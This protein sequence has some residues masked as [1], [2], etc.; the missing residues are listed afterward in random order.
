MQLRCPPDSK[1]SSR[2]EPLGSFLPMG[3]P[4]PPFLIPTW[5]Y[6]R[7]CTVTCVKGKILLPDAEQ[8]SA[9][10]CSGSAAERLKAAQA[11]AVPA[12]SQLRLRCLGV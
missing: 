10:E 5:Q 7:F 8:Q 11:M 4:V 12:G 1:V 9:S 3:L 2:A 6:Q